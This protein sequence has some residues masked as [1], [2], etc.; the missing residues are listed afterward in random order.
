M[1]IGPKPRLPRRRC[2]AFSARSTPSTSRVRRTVF[3]SVALAA[4]LLTVAAA[5][6]A[7]IS[8]YYS[9]GMSSGELANTCCYRARDWNRVYRPGGYNFWLGYDSDGQTISWVGP[10][11]W[12]NPFVDQRNAFS[13]TAWCNNSSPYFVNPVTCQATYP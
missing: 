12:N 6:I 3:L 4:M 13:A 5:A 2:L 7:A 9:G 8:T 11:A 1:P 10:N